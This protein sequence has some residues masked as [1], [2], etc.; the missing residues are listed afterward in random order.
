MSFAMHYRQD[1]LSMFQVKIYFYYVLQQGFAQEKTCQSSI[2][3]R[4]VWYWTT[5][6]QK[7]FTR[8]TRKIVDHVKIW[9]TTSGKGWV[10]IKYSCH[11]LF[12]YGSANDPRTVND[13]QIGP[14]VIPDCKWSP[15]WT[16][17]D[18]QIGTQMIPD[19]K[20]FPYWNASDPG[21]QMIPKLDRKWSWTANDLHIGPQM[22]PTKNME[23][24]DGMVQYPNAI[25]S[26]DTVFLPFHWPGA[27]HVTCE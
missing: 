18:P 25:L 4:L 9:L 27:H 14:Q 11:H 1:K 10:L 23:W 15:N 5:I 24:H 13:P 20:W 6:S 19:Y 22:I 16:V 7:S 2:I 3:T 21:L 12:L 17:N 26:F 8:K